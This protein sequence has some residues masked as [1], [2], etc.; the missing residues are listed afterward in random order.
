MIDP[1]GTK[2]ALTAPFPNITIAGNVANQVSV[3]QEYLDDIYKVKNPYSSLMHKYYGTIFPLWDETAAAIMLDPTIV[4]NTTSFYLDVDTAPSSPNY[5]NIH[6]YQEALKPTAQ[7]LQKVNMVVSIDGNRLKNCTAV[8]NDIGWAYYANISVGNPSQVQAVLIDSGSNELLFTAANATACKTRNGCAGGTFDVTKS[9]TFDVVTRG[10]L[11]IGFEDSSKKKGDYF[12]DEVQIGEISVTNARLGIAYEVSDPTGMNTGIMG[13]GY[14]NNEG[15]NK[16]EPYPTFLDALV[17][18][19]A[20]ES[21]LYGIYL[22]QINSS[23][24]IIFGGIDIAKFQGPMTT[25]DCLLDGR[26]TATEHKLKLDKITVNPHDENS[27]ELLL[28]SGQ[29][30]HAVFLDSGNARCAF[31][32]THIQLTFSGDGLVS[33][34]ATLDLHLADLFAPKVAG[35]S[36]VA[37]DHNGNPLCTLMVEPSGPGEISSIGDAVMRAGYWVFDLD[38]GQISVAQANIEASSSDIV[39]VLKGVDGLSRAV[40]R[41][42]VGDRVSASGDY[43]LA[44]G[45]NPSFTSSLE[46]RFDDAAAT[47]EMSKASAPWPF[48]GGLVL[49]T[50]LFTMLA[51]RC[52]GGRRRQESLLIV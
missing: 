13:L 24:S 30:P 10:G 18:S 6:A 34:T 25:L 37:A 9:S 52:L 47:V 21:R 51:C 35:N 39:K 26:K 3:T 42:F 49:F 45:H 31:D 19:G 40:Q 12:T 38:N 41:H 50:V 16:S 36:G 28:S 29:V 32:T 44:I 48:I 8:A 15:S 11:S 22:N 46:R 7:N 23:G 14:A 1:E 33:N 5:G 4:K 27:E 20:I 2:I 17:Q 43:M